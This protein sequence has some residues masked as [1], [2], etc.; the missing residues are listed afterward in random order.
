MGLIQL[1]SEHDRTLGS[2]AWN[3][4]A[5]T[6]VI[7][8]WSVVPRERG[9]GRNL[10]VILK[11]L[12]IVGVVALLAIFRREPGPAEIPF[13]GTVER[14][15][16]LRTEWWG[17]LGLI[18]WAY[19]TT[20]VLWLILGRRR[21]WLMGALST[22]ILV[23][24]AMRRGGLLTRLDD[25]TWLGWLAPAFKMLAH[26]ISELDHYVGLGDATGSL[27]AISVAGCLLGA[28]LR[29]DSDIA[30]YRERFRWAWT[31]AIGLLLAGLI[32]D[33]FEG[34]NKIA[35]TP[36]WCLWSAALT[37]LAWAALY[38]VIDVAGL[39]GWTILVR[40]AGANPL[41]A[42]FLHPI[43]V[44]LIVVAG[45]G[46]RLLSY[47]NANDPYIVVAGSFG[48]ALFVCGVTGLLGRLGLRTRL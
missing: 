11:A 28:I 31:F 29:R 47:Q 6:C 3:L 8:A 37:C 20:A 32:T 34:I 19:L 40:P 4:L 45:L 46:N 18:G 23:H 39:R 16:W 22:L 35:A 33:T 43:V 30:T 21:E 15:A 5:F 7:F 9:V 26:V 10:L 41:V 44:G 17:I 13:W 27:A 2:L 48:M 24:I 12:G 42:Y 38:R 36:T 1:N 14:W 25:K